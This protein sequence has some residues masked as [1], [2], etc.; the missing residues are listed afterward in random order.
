MKG[1]P[2]RQIL[3]V[4]LAIPALALSFF[5]YQTGN[6][7]CRISPARRDLLGG[8]YLPEPLG[9]HLQISL[10][11]IS[12]FWPLRHLS[13]RLSQF[14]LVSPSI[15]RRTSSLLIA[16][17]RCSGRK[18]LLSILLLL[19]N[20]RCSLRTTANTSFISKTKRIQPNDS[21]RIHSISTPREKPK[22]EQEPVKLNALPAGGQ[23]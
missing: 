3:V 19:T 10:S 16:P 21:H 11:G 1:L 22:G 6:F 17:W 23:K 5:I 2:I 4:L 15:A 9:K 20:T 14:I 12:R 7:L 18:P 13:A 8:L